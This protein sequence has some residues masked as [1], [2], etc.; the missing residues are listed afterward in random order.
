MLITGAS[1]SVC[2]YAAK[3]S[4][5]FPPTEAF[6]VSEINKRQQIN[7]PQRSKPFCI[8]RHYWLCPRQ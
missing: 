2:S 3:L 6:F 1:E 5:Q 4:H 7:Y 8:P